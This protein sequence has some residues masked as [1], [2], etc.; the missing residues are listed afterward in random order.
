[1]LKKP[2]KAIVS[3]APAMKIPVPLVPIETSNI[4]D[5]VCPA[6]LPILN[7]LVPVAPV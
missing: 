1:M 6:V 5:D 2:V 3:V 7:V 4:F